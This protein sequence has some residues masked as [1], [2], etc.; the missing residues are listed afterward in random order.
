MDALT[1]SRYFEVTLAE[2]AKLNSCKETRDLRLTVEQ[3]QYIIFALDYY[4]E[5]LKNKGLLRVSKDVHN[6]RAAMNNVLCRF[7]GIPEASGYENLEI[8]EG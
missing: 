8:Q 5:D 3:I 1:E 7:Y 4:D 2:N 6:L